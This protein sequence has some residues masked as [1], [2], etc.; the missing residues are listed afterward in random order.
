MVCVISFDLSRCFSEGLR[1]KPQRVDMYT[2]SR[3][4][5]TSH[6]SS[7][8]LSLFLFRVISRH[9]DCPSEK[10]GSKEQRRSSKS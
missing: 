4:Q 5:F 1:S 8:N 7:S 9:L 6:T 3:N 2:K 10:R